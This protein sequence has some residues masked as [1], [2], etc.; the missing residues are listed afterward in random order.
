[1]AVTLAVATKVVNLFFVMIMGMVL[2]KAR[3]IDKKS[4]S[5]LSSILVNMTSPFLIIMAFQKPLLPELAKS[6][7]IVLG[8]S[9]LIH[10]AAAVVGALAFRF[11][12]KSANRK[13]YDFALIFANCAFLGYPVLMVL[14]SALG[15]ENGVFYGVFYTLF[16]NIFCWT[17]GVM[18][19][20]D[21]KSLDRKTM[22]RKIFLN[23][24]FIS[25]I[26]G[27]LMFML[28]IEIP[29]FISEGMDYIGNMTFPLSMLIVGSLFCELDL[30]TLL[31]DKAM[32]L[33]LLLKLILFP[34][35]MIFVLKA[36]D[37]PLL[38]SYIIV[39]MCSMP[40]ASNTAIMADYYDANKLLAAK[41][42]GL[43]TVLS[44]LTIPLMI[45][46]TTIVM[47]A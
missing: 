17:Y 14:C 2:R 21:G 44:V 42:V 3:I 9:V 24:S 25:A 34:G 41:V 13:I 16:F 20:N 23:P 12:R 43:S 10:I 47:G 30:K 33:Y 38:Y 4:T 19:M 22:C 15:D 36:L 45:M 18:L 29:V 35:V 32:Y 31:G 5:A 1:M 6:G 37:V 8:A 28:R 26:V 11:E 39:A 40:A 7:F 27:F 46:L